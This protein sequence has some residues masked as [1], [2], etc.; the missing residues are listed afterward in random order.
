MLRACDI[1]GLARLLVLSRLLSTYEQTHSRQ[2]SEACSWCNA[3][4]VTVGKT[5]KHLALHFDASFLVQLLVHS[6][7]RTERMTLCDAANT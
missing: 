4:Q 1:G 3:T 6:F 5:G 7:S 2:H